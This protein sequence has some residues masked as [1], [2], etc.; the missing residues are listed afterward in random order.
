MRNQV[1]S[2]A[3]TRPGPLFVDLLNVSH[4]YVHECVESVYIGWRWR[5][6]RHIGLVRRA[7]TALYDNDP[8]VRELY[9]GRSAR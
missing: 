3:L 4:T 1:V 5:I 8:G 9:E 2:K 6:E 7:A